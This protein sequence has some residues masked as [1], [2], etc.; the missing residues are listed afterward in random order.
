MRLRRREIVALCAL[1]L[2]GALAMDWLFTWPV[3]SN[4]YSVEAAGPLAALLHG[5]VAAF[6][7]SAPAYGP[8]L[9]LRSPFAL[10]G[11]L[12]HGSTLLVYRLGALPCL[13][14]LAA[15]GVYGAVA[16]RAGGHGWPSALLALAI[17]VANPISYYAL[18]IG[19]PEELLGAALCVAAVVAARAGRPLSA[20]V[21]LGL[22]VANKDWGLLAVGPV[23]IALPAQR[24]RAL[25]VAAG[26]AALLLAPIALASS[27]L[28]AAVRRLEMANSGELTFYPQQFWWFLGI[29]GH[30][31]PSM[32]GQV[33]DGF[34]L[35]PTWLRGRAHSLII[36]LGLSLGWLALMRRV[37]RERALSLLALVLLLRCALDP[38]DIVYYTLPFIV[39][40]AS[41]EATCCQRPPWAS[42]AS[43][44][45]AWLVFEAL[46]P[47]ISLDATALAFIAPALVAL[48]ALAFSTYRAGEPTAQST[49]SSSLVNWLRTRAP[50]SATTVR[51]SI[52]TPSTP[53]R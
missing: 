25:L 11:S 18:Q 3:A 47:H 1:A 50:S 41:W 12:A 15:V 38:W 14:A 22:A 16:L 7:R 49:T 36:W 51:S 31:L 19:H 5:H 35:P 53:G 17:C 30:M 26:V 39:A 33:P 42:L 23:I 34:R 4:D 40:L 13:L 52:R 2:V 43:V 45:V 28:T 48:F 27:S 46:P 44:V 10:L 20:G 29:H 9:A 32:R 8:S 21:L 6:L 37:P 24:A